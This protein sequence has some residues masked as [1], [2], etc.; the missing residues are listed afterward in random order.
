MNRSFIYTD[1]DVREMVAMWEEGYSGIHIAELYGT[2]TGY[3]SNIV[4]GMSRTA[5][6]GLK[7][8]YWV[9]EDRQRSLGVRKRDNR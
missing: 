9:P 7:P 8:G 2:S 5:A 3:V 1:E 4:N 6:S